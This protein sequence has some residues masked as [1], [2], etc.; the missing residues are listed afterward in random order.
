VKFVKLCILQVVLCKRSGLAEEGVLRGEAESPAGWK[1]VGKESGSVSV[2]SLRQR[3]RG[4]K[5]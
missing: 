3:Q 1:S 4:E 2:L 5:C